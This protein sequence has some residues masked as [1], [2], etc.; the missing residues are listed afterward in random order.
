MLQLV[1]IPAAKQRFNDYPF[2]LSGG[3]RQRVM[4]AMALVCK[5]SLLIAD[6][7]T[8]ALDVTIQAQILELM[9]RLRDET[10]SAIILI[11]HDLG[12]VA[13]TAERVVVMYAGRE[14]E[15]VPV[16]ALFA[17]PA[18]PYTFGLLNSMPRLDGTARLTRHPGQHPQ[19]VGPADGLPLPSSVRRS[20]SSAAWRRNPS[21]IGCP[22]DGGHD[23]GNRRRGDETWPLC[24][25]RKRACWHRPIP[26]RRRCSRSR[27]WSSTSPS[28]KGSC[29][30]WSDR[31][32]PSTT[33]ASRS[34]AA[35]PSASSARAGAASRPPGRVIL[36][37]IE[38]TSG[39]I[40]FDGQ[41]ILALKG[42]G[43]RR[44]SRE[45][46]IVF[47]DPMA[48][49]NPRMSVGQLISEPMKVHGLV[50][51]RAE[52]IERV[53][54]L[55]RVVGLRP[56]RMT[57]YP[58]EFSGGERQRVGIARA[59]TVD[60]KLLI[61]DEPVSALDVSVRSQIINLL[62]DLQDSSR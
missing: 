32:M 13:E 43:L 15:V 54:E 7:P 12:V 4:I 27:T 14:M 36:R 11:T 30:E 53:A 41:D 51:N 49:L 42:E 37:L 23:A 48:S 62:E 50:S 5:P 61:L 24:L 20:R 26:A 8:T 44:I 25:S 10:G 31:S 34:A 1:R 33:S 56:D 47:Q 46:Q 59:L 60:P 22:M 55:M 29:T 40:V 18:H 2:Q 57:N 39:Q 21:S 16:E 52:M 9:M 19:P 28:T 17:D 3:L 58:H 35:R 6:E 45:M 38:P